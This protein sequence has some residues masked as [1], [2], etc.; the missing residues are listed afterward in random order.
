MYS[1]YMYVF[2]C[3]WK[4]GVLPG[5]VDVIV[6]LGVVIYLISVYSVSPLIQI[7][8]DLHVVVIVPGYSAFIHV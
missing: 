3:E 6:W 7:D 4:E 2:F 1:L 8:T 5:V